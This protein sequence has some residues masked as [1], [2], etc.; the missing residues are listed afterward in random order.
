MRE[1]LSTGA[2]AR[3]EPRRGYVLVDQANERDGRVEAVDAMPAAHFRIGILRSVGVGAQARS[4]HH[5][6]PGRHDR[7][8]RRWS[9]PGRC[10]HALRTREPRCA[11]LC[12]RIPPKEVDHNGE[13]GGVAEQRYEHIEA[14]V[15]HDRASQRR[16]N[17]AQ[18][19]RVVGHDRERH[20]GTHQH[21]HEQEH[22][23][24][25]EARSEGVL[26]FQQ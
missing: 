9:S 21:P 24:E 17:A 7:L 1:T 13:V 12:E 16:E 8:Q 10:M 6:L 3:R 4:A 26:V 25:D 15:V 5:G 18:R 11:N 22:K 19:G 20:V 14:E 23:G 2:P